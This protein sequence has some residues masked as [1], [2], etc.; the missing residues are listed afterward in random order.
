MAFILVNSFFNCFVLVFPVDWSNSE[1]KFWRWVGGSI[2]VLGAL[3]ICRR[4]SLQVLFPYSLV[5]QVISSQ[6]DCGSLS[7]PWHLSLSSGYPSSTSPLM[8]TAIHSP[9]SL[10][11]R[12]FP[13]FSTI[14]FC[15]SRFMQSSLIHFDLSFV[16]GDRNGSICSLLQS[17][18]Q[19]G[20]HHL[21][22][23]FL[24]SI[25]SF[26]AFLSKIK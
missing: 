25:G 18:H 11:S 16:E 15:I 6:Q 21:L 19:L 1:L 3:S 17:D 2:P 4:Q 13:I 8:L 23:C 20:Q 10:C 9:R 7:N 12:F 24:F 5:F 14:S 26:L 22:K